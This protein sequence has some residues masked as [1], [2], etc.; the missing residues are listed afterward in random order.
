MDGLYSCAATL[1]LI[2][3]LGSDE[4][5][6]RAIPKG[7][8]D[9]WH[10][11]EKPFQCDECHKR[12]TRKSNLTVHLRSHTGEKPFQCEECHKRFSTKGDL[13]AHSGRFRL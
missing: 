12:F 6:T 8:S 2:S 11:G 3:T 4:V 5:A 1:L 7:G 13:T 10:T 9:Q